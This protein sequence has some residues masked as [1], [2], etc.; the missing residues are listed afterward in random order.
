MFGFL[1]T[2]LREAGDGPSSTGAAA[3]DQEHF[4]EQTPTLETGTP[5][6][7][8]DHVHWVSTC[9]KQPPCDNTLCVAEATWFWRKGRLQS[10]GEEGGE[11]PD[12]SRPAIR[13][14]EMGEDSKG[15]SCK[16]TFPPRV[17]RS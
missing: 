15:Q 14:N 8:G 6:A 16:E 4:G 5:W 2:S 10:W 3:G 17:S 1:T 12:H 7:C 13:N 9:G 11:K